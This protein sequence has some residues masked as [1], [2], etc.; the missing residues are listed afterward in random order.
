MQHEQ[1]D[2]GRAERHQCRAD[3]IAGGA[4]LVAWNPGLTG[5]FHSDLARVDV[6]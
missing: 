5:C 1:N 6:L 4:S 2:A 3:H